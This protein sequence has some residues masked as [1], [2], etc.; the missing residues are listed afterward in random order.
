MPQV[1]QLLNNERGSSGFKAV[2]DYNDIANN[3]TSSNQVVLGTLPAGALVKVVSVYEETALA[4]ATDITLDVGVTT[5]DPDEFIDALDVD[6]MT[7]P[8]Y[9]TGDAFT[10]TDPDT[11][12]LYPTYQTEQTVYIEWNGTVASL[13]AGRVIIELEYKDLGRFV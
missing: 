1:S 8:V 13:T 10:A 3:A 5:G 12:E 6:A 4:G 7:K 9:N 11:D 2:F